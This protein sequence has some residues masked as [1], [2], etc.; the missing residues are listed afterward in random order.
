MPRSAALRLADLRAIHTLAGECR[1]LGDDAVQWRRRLLDGLGRLAGGEFCVAGELG[2]GTRPTR[3]T[4]GT[5][6]CGADNGFNRSYWL[7]ALTEFQLDAFFNPHMNAIFNRNEWRAARP[8]AALVPDGEWYAS[9]CFQEV[10]RALG[11]DVSLLCITPV[12]VARQDHTVLYLMRHIGAREFSDRE[13]AIVA[14][15]MAQIAPLVGGPLARFGE[16]SPAA[17]PARTRAVLRCL[18]EG[19]TDKQ[20]AA[21]LGMTRHTVNQHA[22]AVFRHFGV[23]SRAELLARWVRRGW[24][25][26]GWADGLDG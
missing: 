23:T 5:V 22:K 9:F 11:A 7:K 3:Y 25:V 13:R 12:P 6:D 1:E 8:R 17:L 16:P 24:G 21:R 14:E 2:D 18:L 10:V 15:A 26:G 19:D 4:R 20:V